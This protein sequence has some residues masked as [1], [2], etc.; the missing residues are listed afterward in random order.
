MLFVYLFLCIKI[1]GCKVELGVFMDEF[2]SI[3]FGD[4]IWEKNFIVVLVDGFFNF[5]LNGI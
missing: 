1:L 3:I 2:G 4:F 5:G